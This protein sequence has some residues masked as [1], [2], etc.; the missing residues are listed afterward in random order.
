MKK[1][2]VRL[3]AVGSVLRVIGVDLTEVPI[4]Q[5]QVERVP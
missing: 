3:I 1:T 5:E 2:A 4:V